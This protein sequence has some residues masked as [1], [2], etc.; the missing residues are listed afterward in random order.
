MSQVEKRNRISKSAVALLMISVIAVFISFWKESVV[1][2]YFGTS[3]YMDAYN[4]SVDTPRNIFDA[5]SAAIAY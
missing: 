4:I 5:I 2:Y 3:Q 1:A